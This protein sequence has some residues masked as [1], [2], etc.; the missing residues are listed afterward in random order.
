MQAVCLLPGR[1]G[2]KLFKQEWFKNGTN[3]WGATENSPLLEIFKTKTRLSSVS[4]GCLVLRYCTQHGVGIVK[5]NS[6]FPSLVSS[7]SMIML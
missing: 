4:C 1:F 6:V 2:E 7:D 3:Y 5:F